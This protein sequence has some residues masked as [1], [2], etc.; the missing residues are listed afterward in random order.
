MPPN[1]GW[2]GG[3]NQTHAWSEWSDH[4]EHVQRVQKGLIDDLNV[5][6][7]K[8]RH[9]LRLLTA[10]VSLFTN[11]TVP[12]PISL[13]S[14]IPAP[15]SSPPWSLP[16]LPTTPDRE[17]Q[18]GMIGSFSEDFTPAMFPE[19]HALHDGNDTCSGM[20]QSA[21]TKN[22]MQWS[23]L[24]TSFRECQGLRIE[25]YGKNNQTVRFACTRCSRCT[26]EI[27]ARKVD[28]NG[29]SVY[30]E[31][32]AEKKWFWRWLFAQI[33]KVESL[34]H[35]TVN[36]DTLTLAA[37][38]PPPLPQEAIQNLVSDIVA[39]SETVVEVP[40]QTETVVEVSS[41]NLSEAGIV[42]P[43][44]PDDT[45]EVQPVFEAAPTSSLESDNG[46]STDL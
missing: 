29:F 43:L 46:W 27:E 25:R 15:S 31:T 5:E 21:A 41:E 12:N 22:D 24:E 40:S 45:V 7:V 19:F 42:E 36:R 20:L 9:E 13:S 2:H 38:P 35:C 14:A 17:C 11:N 33:L 39:P 16:N 1:G 3:W 8:L 23:L 34:E 10:H 4:V 18:H 32:P 26:K 30:S 44:V 6:V 37:P 28:S